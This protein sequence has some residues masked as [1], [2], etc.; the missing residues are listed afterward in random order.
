MVAW[1]PS[2]SLPE[3]TPQTGVK[4]FGCSAHRGMRSRS[5][6]HQGASQLATHATRRAQA[7]PAVL[8]A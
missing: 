8:Q 7:A 3:S 6:Q 2:S 4:S 5:F 1:K